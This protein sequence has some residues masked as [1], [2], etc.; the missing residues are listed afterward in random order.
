MSTRL[1]SLIVL[2]GATVNYFCQDGLSSLT[3]LHVG[4]IL[5]F[6]G[7]LVPVNCGA[8]NE[9]AALDQAVQDMNLKMT[10]SELLPK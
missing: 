10:H 9:Y 4:E 1:H 5:N 2:K 3:V 6:G 8:G 7:K